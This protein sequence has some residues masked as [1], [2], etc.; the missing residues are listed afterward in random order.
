MKVTY[1]NVVLADFPVFYE[2][3]HRTHGNIMGAEYDNERETL[4]IIY[5]PSSAPLNR[6]DLPLDNQPVRVIL[7]KVSTQA[8]VNDAEIVVL[9][10]S[11]NTVDFLTTSKSEAIKA[12]K[13]QHP[14]FVEVER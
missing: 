6:E 2:Y 13:K 4:T 8:R 1:K 12:V 10:E 9:H 3:V 14:D 5:Q 7:Q 11:D